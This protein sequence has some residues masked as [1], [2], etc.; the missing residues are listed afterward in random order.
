M[1][2]TATAYWLL[3]A[4]ILIPPAYIVESDYSDFIKFMVSAPSMYLLLMSSKIEAWYTAAIEK[5]NVKMWNKENII[6]N[7][8]T[9]HGNK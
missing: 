3:M 1:I 7:K 6:R 4:L 9:N 2:N 5:R 8:E